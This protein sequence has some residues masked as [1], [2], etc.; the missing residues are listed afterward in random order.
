MGSIDETALDR[1]SYETLSPRAP[2]RQRLPRLTPSPRALAGCSAQARGGAEQAHP[3]HGPGGR[4]RQQE[5]G[6]ARRPGAL[7]PQGAPGA[8]WTATLPHPLALPHHPRCRSAA[9]PFEQFLWLVRDFSLKLESNGREISA[10]EY[11]E[12]SLQPLDVRNYCLAQRTDFPWDSRSLGA[13]HRAVFPICQGDPERV[14]DRNLIR[15]SITQYFPDRTCFTLKRPVN[16]EKLLQVR[17]CNAVDA[18]RAERC[19]SHA[20]HADPNCATRGAAASRQA[21]GA[22]APAAVCRGAQGVDLAGVQERAPQAPL[23]PEPERF[24]SVPSP[25]ASCL[26]VVRR[27]GPD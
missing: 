24:Q 27:R 17:A 5:E 19:G 10:K 6:Q 8:G 20:A 16:D 4:R 21:V 7:L 2:S 26:H 13:L 22:G 23:Q 25:L 15:T 18:R 9:A 1:L 14:K 12:N 3:N 11:L